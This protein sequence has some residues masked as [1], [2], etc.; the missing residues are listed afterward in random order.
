MHLVLMICCVCG[1]GGGRLKDVTSTCNEHSTCTQYLYYNFTADTAISCHCQSQNSSEVTDLQFTQREPGVEAKSS[2]TIPLF[3][4][5][6]YALKHS[7]NEH[8][9]TMPVDAFLH[10]STVSL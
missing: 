1:G 2:E 6:M 9:A 4:M 7:G 8:L 10:H 5:N 3:L